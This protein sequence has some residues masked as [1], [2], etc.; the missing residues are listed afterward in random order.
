MDTKNPIR[1]YLAQSVR[2]NGKLIFIAFV[3]ILIGGIILATIRVLPPIV[4][5]F[6]E[7]MLGEFVVD[8]PLK[9][10]FIVIPLILFYKSKFH[11]EWQEANPDTSITKSEFSTAI[12]LEIFLSTFIGIV[13]LL[14]VWI[15]AGLVDPTIIPRILRVGV[16]SLGEGFLWVWLMTTLV[17]TLQFTP[18]AKISEGALLLC[19]AL[20]GSLQ[21]VVRLQNTSWHFINDVGTPIP[22]VV[23]TYTLVALVILV[24][25]RT[26]T[27][28]LYEKRNLSS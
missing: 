20:L 18:F 24:I 6:S 15:V 14:I 23:A 28:R 1:H 22:L 7:H 2:T 10:A 3:L 8:L 25:G 4:N 16:F 13:A 27:A 19:A 11:E 26:I 17:Y 5:M 21:V 12:Y 9:A